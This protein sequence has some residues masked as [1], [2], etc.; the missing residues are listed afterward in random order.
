MKIR[1]L[2]QL[3]NLCFNRVTA[4]EADGVHIDD[5]NVVDLIADQCDA[6]LSVIREALALTGFRGR[7]PKACADV[8]EAPTDADFH[9]VTTFEHVELESWAEANPGDG[10]QDSDLVIDLVKAAAPPMELR[11]FARNVYGDVK[12]YPV[13]DAANVLAEIAGN[14]TLTPRT[15]T[16]AAQLGYSTTYVLDPRTT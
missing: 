10:R 4:A 9:V 7:F 3:S 11:V 1:T 8:T 12:V 6:D 2:R 14:T 5:G 15:L 16:L 13:N